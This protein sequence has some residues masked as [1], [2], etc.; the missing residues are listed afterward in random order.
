MDDGKNSTNEADSDGTPSLEGRDT[1]VFDLD[2]TLYPASS[3]LFDQVDR[4]IGAFIQQFLSLNAMEART[5][6]KQYFRAFGTTLRGLTQNH[7]ANP[8][9]FLDFVHDIDFSRI[10]PDPSLAAAIARLPGRKIIFT[11]ADAAYAEKV[12]KRIGV[13]QLFDGIFDIEAADFLP[14]SHAQTYLG[15]LEAHGI[16]PQRAVLVDDIPRNLAPAAALGMTTVWIRNDQWM[17]TGS[18]TDDL[19]FDHVVEDLTAWL[20]GVATA[21]DGI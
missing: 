7:G 9:E 20:E 8:R 21:F 6:Q 1:W 13:W 10:F 2:N 15:L 5:L 16:E 11:N 19:E 3:N 18:A 14:K 4:R 12:M 17:E